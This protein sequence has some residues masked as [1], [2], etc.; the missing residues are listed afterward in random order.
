MELSELFELLH[1][2]D[3]FY[4]LENDEDGH[5]LSI[6][7]R[8]KYPRIWVDNFADSSPSIIEESVEHIEAR[9]GPLVQMDWRERFY[10]KKVQDVAIQ[11]T[12]WLSS[13]PD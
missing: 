5:V 3:M 13:L 7:S 1:S 8:K 11:A 4:R 12:A 6:V 9:L 2:K 10:G